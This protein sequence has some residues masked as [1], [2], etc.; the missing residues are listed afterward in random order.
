MELIFFIICIWHSPCLEP[1]SHPQCFT[2]S[3][4]THSIFVE[5]LLQQ[6]RPPLL[7]S[8]DAVSPNIDLMMQRSLLTLENLDQDMNKLRNSDDQITIL[9][10]QLSVQMKNDILIASNSFK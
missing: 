5:Q 6:P 9:C 1:S 3:W 10:R 7:W 2:L 8:Q 4:L